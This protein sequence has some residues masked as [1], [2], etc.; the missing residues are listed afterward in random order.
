MPNDRSP[1]DALAGRTILIIEDDPIMLRN[2]AQWFQQAG[3]KVVAARDGVEGLAQFNE[4]RPDA[5][6][7]DI[8]M[9]NRE[10][11]ETLMAIKAEAPDVKIL[12]ISGGGRL[13]SADLLAMAY[14]L[15]ADAVMAKPFRSTEIISAVA[16]L[17]QPKDG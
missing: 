13:G 7:T 17:F 16:R 3:C 5:V 15:G 2:L 12:A 9:P 4:V 1:S 6:V 11:V 10:G 14:S 8:I